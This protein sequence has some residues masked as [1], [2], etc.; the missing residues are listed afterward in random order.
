LR[1]VS[2]FTALYLGGCDWARRRYARFQDSE[3][4]ANE[5]RVHALPGFKSPSLRSSQTLS[6]HARGEGLTH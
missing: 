3:G 1:Q 5:V 6:R 4:T 2:R